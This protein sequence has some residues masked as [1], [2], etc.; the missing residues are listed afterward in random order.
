MRHSGRSYTALIA[1]G[2]AA[3]LLLACSAAAYQQF[4]SVGK[5]ADYIRGQRIFIE[6]AVLDLGTVPG[7]TSHGAVLVVEN[8][9]SGVV[10]LVGSKSACSCV[11]IS[12]LPRDVSPGKSVELPITI[13]TGQSDPVEP[14]EMRVSLVVFTDYPKQPRLPGVVTWQFV[15]G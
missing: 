12:D 3:L 6:P 8:L 1:L 9:S 10:R 5:A 14:T 11:T 7:E 13:R 2:G 4:G 15:G